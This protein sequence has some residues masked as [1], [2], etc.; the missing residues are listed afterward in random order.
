M[1]IDPEVFERHGNYGVML[2]ERTVEERAKYH[3]YMAKMYAKS[4]RTELALQYLRKSLEE[5]FKDKKI[6]EQPEF[7]ALR[8][9]P[10]FKELLA[11]EPRVL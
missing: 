6:A 4:G 10:E 2:E 3:Y 5:G 11:R 9:L 8:D 7:A 1:R